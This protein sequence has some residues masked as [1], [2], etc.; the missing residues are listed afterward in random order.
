MPPSPKPAL[1]VAA[2]TGFSA[3]LIVAALVVYVQGGDGDGEERTART[4]TPAATS[5]TPTAVPTARFAP[6]ISGLKLSDDPE[7]PARAAFPV[8]DRLFAC[9]AA[10]GGTDTGTLTLVATADGI[11]APPADGTGIVARSLPVAQSPDHACYRLD[12]ERPPLTP[13]AYQV[14]VVLGNAV[15]ARAPF[16]A[17]PASA[18]SAT[19]QPSRTATAPA[20]SP[21]S[22]PLRTPTPP[23]AVQTPPPPQPTA[24]PPPQPTA[25]PP[26]PPTP[27]PTPPPPLP[28]AVPTALPTPAPTAVPPTPMR[29]VPP[30]ALDTP[31]TRP[32]LMPPPIPTVRPTGTPAG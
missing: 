6:T 28:T 21:T 17:L 5:S 15:L 19:A 2:A 22:A 31:T 24:P 32:T 1:L 26:P 7:A 8:S 4:A 12:V 29:T 3:L 14:M 25:P 16:S 10:Q 27:A 20:A 18:A 30:P 11:T 13:G 9:F 23:P